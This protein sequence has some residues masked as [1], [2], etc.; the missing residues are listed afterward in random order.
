MGKLGVSTSTMDVNGLFLPD[1]LL[2]L[3]V[4]EECEL[5]LLCYLSSKVSGGVSEY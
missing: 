3:S 2:D 5:W 1:P 4:Q